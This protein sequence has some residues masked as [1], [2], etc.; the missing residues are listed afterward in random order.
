MFC[1]KFLIYSIFSTEVRFL[2]DEIK[3]YE[4]ENI[5]L[6]LM[7]YGNNELKKIIFKG[8]LLKKMS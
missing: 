5:Y 2:E 3:N 6:K 4:Y 1:G 8:V 7:Q